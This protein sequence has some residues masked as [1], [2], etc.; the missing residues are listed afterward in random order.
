MLLKHE[1]NKVS[2][3]S[4]IAL[5][6]KSIDY[7]FSSYFELSQEKCVMQSK[8]ES[9]LRKRSVST[10]FLTLQRFG[11]HCLSQTPAPFEVSL[12]CLIPSKVRFSYCSLV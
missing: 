2:R 6:P 9:L 12:F 10:T 5:H 11:F 1:S 3:F 4:I 7:Y 8:N